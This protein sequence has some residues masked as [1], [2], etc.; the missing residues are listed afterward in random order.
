MTAFDCLYTGGHSINDVYSTITINLGIYTS[1]PPPHTIVEWR[2]IGTYTTIWFQS[3]H[4]LC[5]PWWRI[6]FSL[7]KNKQQNLSILRLKNILIIVWYQSVQGNLCMHKLCVWMNRWF[8]IDFIHWR[9]ISAGLKIG[10]L[11]PCWSRNTLFLVV[12]FFFFFLGGGITSYLRLGGVF[13]RDPLH[14]PPCLYSTMS[15]FH[16]VFTPPCLCS[17]VS[18]LHH[19]Y[20]PPCLYSTMSMFLRVFTPPYL[21]STLSLLHN[22]YVPLCLYSTMSVFHHVFTLPYLCS[23]MSLLHRVYDPPCLCSTVSWLHHVHVSMFHR[24]C[25]LSCPCSTMSMFY[26][27]Y[28][29]PRFYS[30]ISMFHRVF[31]P[32]CLC[33]YVAPCLCCTVFLLHHVYV[34]T[35]LYSPTM[36]LFH[37]VIST[38]SMFRMFLLHHVYVP[39]CL[40]STIS[41]DVILCG[42]LG[43]KHQ[44]T[45]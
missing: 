6:F 11:L 43:S 21:C 18:F 13:R 2:E 14:V 32:Q 37:R 15:M 1:P 7:K 4:R 10:N 35:C 16:R 38:M 24:V 36:S 44:L 31:T 26:H 27:V 28:V 33:V 8:C 12:V 3:L 17:T 45:H 30:T 42:W 22:I 19:V 40:Y 9:F 34:P 20:V 23:T 39:P 5:S 25:L 29:P 41:P